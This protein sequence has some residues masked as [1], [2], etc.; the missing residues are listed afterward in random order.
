MSPKH[1][2]YC[3]I[4]KTIVSIFEIFQFN[5]IQY[6]S[7]N[8]LWSVTIC[9]A[10]FTWLFTINISGA[11]WL[12]TFELVNISMSENIYEKT[13]EYVLCTWMQVV[14]CVTI[15]FRFCYNIMMCS[16]WQ[17]QAPNYNII[18]TMIINIL[19]YFGLIEIEFCIHI[20]SAWPTKWRIKSMNGLNQEMRSNAR[21]ILTRRI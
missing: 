19:V 7:D 20:R 10:R 16:W 15:Y 17:W 6:L 8:C 5:S 3:I 13:L 1:Y 18:I 11:P 2:Y 12:T 4:I 14:K 9:M 21:I